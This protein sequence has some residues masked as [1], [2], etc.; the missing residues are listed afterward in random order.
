MPK[1]AKIVWLGTTP[2]TAI[3]PKEQKKLHKLMKTHLD[4]RR[5]KYPEVR[6]KVVDYIGHSIDDGV[7]CIDVCLKDKTLF[8]FR[9]ACEVFIVGAGLSDWKTN[10]PA[11]ELKA[12]KV[13]L[14]PTLPFNNEEM[15]QILLARDQ[16]KEEM[17]SHGVENGRRIRA[18]VL[19]LRYSG[20]ANR[21][22][23]KFQLL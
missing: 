19:L 16:Y 17:S 1:K 4:M 20:I 14:C 12:P 9:F 8:S 13:T 3:T 6:G 23:G 5:R 21:S 2:V 15:R 18:V 10:N 11:M 22:C 7:L